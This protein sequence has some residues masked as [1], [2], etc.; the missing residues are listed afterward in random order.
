MTEKIALVV[1]GTGMAAYELAPHLLN[2]F[3]GK[4]SFAKVAVLALGVDENTFKGRSERA[5]IPLK[6]A[7]LNNMESIAKALRECDCTQVTHVYWFL[8][9]NRPPKLGNAVMFRKGLNLATGLKKI[10]NLTIDGSPG[11]L[12]HKIFGTLA[13]LAGS[14]SQPR[15]IDWLNNTFH[16]LEEVDAPIQSFTLGTGGKH[17]GMHLGPSMFSGYE[18]PFEEDKHKCP[19]PLSYFEMEDFIQARAKAKGF[20]WNCVRPTFIIGLAPEMT[21][22]TQSF[23]LVFG[24]YAAILKEQGRPLI[25]PGGK[26][27]WNCRLQLSTSKKIAQVAAWCSNLTA[28]GIAHSRKSSTDLDVTAVGNQAFNVV[29]CDEFSWGE[30]WSDLANYFHMPSGGEPVD[31]S[32]SLAVDI[33]G[34]EKEAARVWELLQKKYS[35]AD[36]KFSQVFNADFFDKSFTSTWDSQFST[37]K[38]IKCGYPKDQ[39]FEGKSALSIVT[40][41]M[42][43]LKESKFIPPQ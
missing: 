28:D 15:N 27:A 23:G 32:G 30:I 24:V 25:F 20:R 11:F 6:G 17:Y 40:N 12:K 34:G 10:I 35:L 4:H 22:V 21:N 1:G 14:G 7:N 9:A 43:T 37:K 33:I 19:G 36:Y 2:D 3:T 29:S 16:A 31:N 26:G 8:D 18:T 13:S 38:L 42:D 5:V 41:F 39:I